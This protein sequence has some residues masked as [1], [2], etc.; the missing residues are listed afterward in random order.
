MPAGL[1]D[2]DAAWGVGA[3]QTT[4]EKG[5]EWAGI[6]D[7]PV[8]RQIE[9]HS[10][11][12]DARS[13]DD[14]TKLLPG[15]VLGQRTSDSLFAHYNPAATDGTEV[16]V[17][18]LAEQHTMKGADTGTV[19]K[20]L[21]LMCVHG[22]IRQDQCG[23]LDHSARGDMASRI[24]FDDEFLGFGPGTL[25][26]VVKSA[27]HTVTAAQKGTFFTTRGAAAAVNFTLPTLARG[28]W[29]EFFNEADQNMTVT[30]AAD[31]GVVK[32]DLAADSASA[33][34]ASEKI[35]AHF[36]VRAN[37]D[38]SKWLFTSFGD[39]TVTVAT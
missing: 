33:S 26:P 2:Y 1:N 5:I 27:D 39:H 18:I 23:G 17:G 31:T 24:Y 8:T 37:D 21:G 32:N 36:R 25:G 7:L 20:K 15:L 28:L 10:S 14:T 9:L 29:F 35:G 12:V 16:A 4:L 30:F 11:T 6:S 38:A 34:T 3:A 22:F 19:E 13:T